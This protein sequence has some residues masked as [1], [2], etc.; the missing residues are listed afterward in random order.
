MNTSIDIRRLA[1]FETEEDGTSISLMAEDVSPIGAQTRRWI[2]LRPSRSS[3]VAHTS[4]GL[5]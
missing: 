3:S 2:G 5:S 1:R 4:M